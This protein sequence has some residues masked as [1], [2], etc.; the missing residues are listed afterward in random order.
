[1]SCLCAPSTAAE[2]ESD[3]FPKWGK[4]SHVGIFLCHSPH[5]AVSVPLILSTQ[6]GLVNPQFHCVFDDDFDTVKKEQHDTSIWQRRAHLQAT[7]DKLRAATVN[8]VPVTQPTLTT[9]T[10]LLPNYGANIP[11]TLQ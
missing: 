11:A 2:S 8:V 1:M 10:S 6:A 9:K 5:H 3:L 4:H 7:Q